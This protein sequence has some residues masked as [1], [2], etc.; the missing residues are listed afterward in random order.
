MAAQQIQAETDNK[1]DL[2]ADEL[3]K[4]YAPDLMDKV[5]VNWMPYAVLRSSLDLDVFA[6]EVS[7]VSNAYIKSSNKVL[8]H[9]VFEGLSQSSI[10][11]AVRTLSTARKSTIAAVDMEIN[12]KGT[13]KSRNKA[14]YPDVSSNPFAEESWNKKK[15]QKR[16][17]TTQVDIHRLLK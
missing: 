12:L 5:L 2:A 14:K 7:R 4:F 11:D 17:R 13:T 10:A 8:K 1:T 15:Q 6:P 9:K 16:P 3:N